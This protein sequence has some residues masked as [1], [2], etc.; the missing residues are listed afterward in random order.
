MSS[1]YALGYGG[2]LIYVV[3]DQDLVAVVTSM[4]GESDVPL[5]LGLIDDYIT[6]SVLE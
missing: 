2:Q 4:G 3:P 5:Y 1:F 6:A